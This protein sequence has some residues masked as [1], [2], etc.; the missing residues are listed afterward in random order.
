MLCRN[1]Q[2]VRVSSYTQEMNPGILVGPNRSTDTDS[3]SEEAMSPPAARDTATADLVAGV[4]DA[5]SAA[6]RAGSHVASL[7]HGATASRLH[8]G[9]LFLQHGPI[10]LVVRAG[11]RTSAVDRGARGI[12][13]RVSGLARHAGRRAFAPAQSRIS[14]AGVTGRDNRPPHGHCGTGLRHGRI[15]H[16]HG[17]GGRLRGRRGGGGARGAVG[18]GARIREQRRRHRPAS[19]SRV[20][21]VGRRGADAARGDPA[22]AHIEIASDSA[23]RGIATSG[24]RG[25]SHSLGIADAVTVLARSAALADAAATLIANAVDV[26]HPGIHRAAGSRARRGQRPRRTMPV[27]VGGARTGTRVRSTPRSTQGC[28][29]AD[30]LCR[31]PGRRRRCRAHRCRVAGACSEARRTDPDLR[32][33]RA[34]ERTHSNRGTP[35]NAHEHT[36]AVQLDTPDAPSPRPGT[37]LVILHPQLVRSH[38]PKQLDGPDDRARPEG[39]FSLSPSKERGFHCR[40]AAR[41]WNAEH[42][43]DSG[44]CAPGT[45]PAQSGWR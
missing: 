42:T 43:R 39:M 24:W 33:C 5:A 27:T 19:E 14:P 23:V 12:D 35:G 44:R 31:R 2:A 16:P 26:D 45:I 40:P 28:W 1:R 17:G 22:R 34:R 13:G 38:C 18:Y 15:R 41:E 11:G 7:A 20:A 25:R 29:T 30:A 32:R 8:G 3:G 9:R 37:G 36:G 10:N 4:G 21:P 6:L